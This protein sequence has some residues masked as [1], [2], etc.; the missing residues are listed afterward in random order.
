MVVDVNKPHAP[1]VVEIVKV[2]RRTGSTSLEI[3]VP[4]E[5]AKKL[6]LKP[7]DHVSVDLYPEG[8]LTV[9]RVPAV[10]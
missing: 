1:H 5:F 4:S 9:K 7:G 8:T 2:R 3:T 10:K 6:G